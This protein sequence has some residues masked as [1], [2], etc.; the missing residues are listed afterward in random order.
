MSEPVE[1]KA[2][3]SP[4]A[5]PQAAPDYADGTSRGNPVELARAIGEWVR[6]CPPGHPARAW[7][8]DRGTGPEAPE[9][10]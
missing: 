3:E 9:A 4:D 8:A 2:G 1:E 10:G 6:Q 5:N 7:A